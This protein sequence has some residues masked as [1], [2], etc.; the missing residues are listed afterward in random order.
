MKKRFLLLI[1]CVSLVS[2]IWSQD[3]IVTKDARNIEAKVMEIN[4]DNIKYKLSANP[5]GPI[6]TML[7]KDISSVIYK[8]GTIDLF[9]DYKE[10]KLP[11]NS[12]FPEKEK[13]DFL[14]LSDDD[15]E[16]LLKKYDLELYEKF[17]I[18]QE[19]SRRGWR[20]LG[21]GIALT[22]VG[23]MAVIVGA[24]HNDKRIYLT[25]GYLGCVVGE[26][27]IIASIPQ[28]AVG[29]AK[30]KQVQDEFEKKYLSTTHPKGSFQIQL[31]GNG[32]GL[33]YVF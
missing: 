32:V 26:A 4:I 12:D 11:A 15:Q 22:G 19:I 9:D 5:E 10:E 2:T 13:K 30:K 18:G 8:N 17:K 23:L 28:M 25:L 27:F 3:I 14:G 33:A 21:G 29:G 6:Y 16:F 7:K 20:F 31:S 24:S 1:V